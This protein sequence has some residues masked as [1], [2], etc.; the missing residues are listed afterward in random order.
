MRRRIVLATVAVTMAGI[1]VFGVPLAIVARRVVRD[2]EL[3]RLDREADAVAF[4]IDDDVE[5]RRPVDPNQVRRVVRHD[6]RVVVTDPDGRR[7][8]VGEPVEG[9]FLA[10]VVN[11][12]L[13]TTVRIE[14]PAR[15]AN[16]RTVGAIALVA[17]LGTAGIA[18]AVVLAVV[19]AGR[20]ARPLSR[21]AEVSRRL[22]AGDFSARAGEYGIPEADAVSAALNS[23][24]RRLEALLEA[25]R[26]FSANAS[27]QLR[28]PLTALRL[29]VEELA[30]SAD[31]ATRQDAELA[32]AEADRLEQTIDDLLEFA[33]RGR[34]GPREEL[35]VADVL[36]ARERSW[37]RLAAASGRRAAV[38]VDGPCLALASGPSLTQALDALVDNAVRHGGGT[39]T[40]AA[41]RH[42]AAIEVVVSDEGSGVPPG[43]EERI[44]ERHLSLRGGSGVGLALAR[45]LVEADGGRLDLVRSRPATFRIL[46]PARSQTD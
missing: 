7:T 13:G 45:S 14:A 9:G 25:E 17:G 26:S 40:V 21:L 31:A 33:R 1:V 5:A 27:H 23:T 35:D 15:Q 20:L 3:K 46:L 41:R 39:V 10:V 43:G 22:G 16:Q 19:V 44:F 30:S 6:R 38:R 34:V 8:I 11:T 4:A 2:S 28:T 42:G 24:A 36:R 37:S 32:L 29:H 12:S 18:V